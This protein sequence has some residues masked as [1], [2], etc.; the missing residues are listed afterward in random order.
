VNSILRQPKKIKLRSQTMLIIKIENHPSVKKITAS[1]KEDAG[2][3][4]HS[5]KLTYPNVSAMKL[6]VTST[7]SK[8]AIALG[9]FK[10][11]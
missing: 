5:Q 1:S 8:E 7:H 10:E 4:L 3:W 6:G 9:I 11:E 2:M